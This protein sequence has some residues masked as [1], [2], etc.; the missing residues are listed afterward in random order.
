MFCSEWS[1]VKQEFPNITVMPLRCRCWHCDECRPGRTKRLVEEAKTGLPTLFI[2]LTSRRR[3]D[4]TPEWAARELVK[5]WRNL[6]RQY[7]YKHGKGSIPFLCVFEATKK[8]WPHLHIVAR[9]PWVSHKWLKKEMGRMHDS[10]IVDVRRVQGLAKVAHYISKY[11]SKNPHRFEGVK[12]YWRSLDFLL[13]CLDPEPFKLLAPDGWQIIKQN[14]REYAAECEA[15]G[16]AAE[17]GRYQV[18]LSWPQGP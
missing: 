8:G 3:A 2:T 13:P 4:R 14:W 12:R 18:S 1:L 7:V 15:E 6:R 10:P 5:C 11:I 17:W 16:L 9:A